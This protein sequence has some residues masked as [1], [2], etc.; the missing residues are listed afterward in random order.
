MPS[1]HRTVL[2]HEAIDA[3][4]IEPSNIVLDGTL[5]GAGHAQEILRRLGPEGRLIAL[6]ADKDAIERAAEIFKN[7]ARVHL[8][9]DN[10]RNLGDRLASHGFDQID[11]AVFDLGWSG[12]QLAS[13]RGFSFLS[14]E[15]LSMTYDEAQP[16]TAATIVNKWEAS[17]I[18]DV[19]R[20]W[21]EERY[22]KR[23]AKRIVSE[24]EK[25]TIATARELAEIVKAAVPA[26]YRHGRIHPAT[27]TF[28]ALRIAVNDELGALEDGLASAWRML[29]PGGRIAV[30]TFHSIEDRI[31][32]RLFREREDEGSGK[33]VTK[34]PLT[35]SEEEIATNPRSRSAKL[36]VIEKLE[37]EKGTQDQQIHSV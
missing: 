32:K 25:K 33:R 16:L 19:I 5:G 18:E 34:K 24:R 7:D 11:A 27:K 23:I 29:A 9:H 30:I 2:L 6:D 14:D 10:F 31:V 22:A 13:G 8:I 15:P 35:P 17:S 36:R 37:Y 28:Q 12:Y 4:N 26:P 21:G 20:G 1:G 3:L